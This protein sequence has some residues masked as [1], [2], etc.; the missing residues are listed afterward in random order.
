MNVYDTK[1]AF[2]INAGTLAQFGVKS[3]GVF[4]GASAKRRAINDLGATSKL[5]NQQYD[6]KYLVFQTYMK[7]LAPETG[8]FGSD[9]FLNEFM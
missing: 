5:I 7:D 8:A 2:S 9:T 1:Q 3:Y 4:L 6:Q